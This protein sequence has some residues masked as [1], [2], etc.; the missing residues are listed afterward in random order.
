MLHLL[1]HICNTPNSLVP[2]SHLTLSYPHPHSTK[3]SP[4]S[5]LVVVQVLCY[6]CC[7]EFGTTSLAIHQKTCLK[8]HS[9]GLENNILHEPG[10]NVYTCII[11][12]KHVL[13]YMCLC[14]LH[15]H[16]T[17]TNIVCVSACIM[18]MMCMCMHLSFLILSPII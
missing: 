7:A 17:C 5:N 3:P 9:W 1:C 18:E 6:I 12:T 2:H 14:V 10:I 13:I 4:L 15:R 16:E 11:V 8:K